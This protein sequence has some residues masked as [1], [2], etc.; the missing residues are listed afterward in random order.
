MVVKSAVFGFFIVM[1][2]I[3]HGIR[4]TNELTSI[5]AA[6]LIGMVNVF[7]AIVVIIEVLSL[8][9]TPMITKLI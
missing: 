7:I 2:P 5:S 8:V 4:A 6:V 1:I 9:I 3:R